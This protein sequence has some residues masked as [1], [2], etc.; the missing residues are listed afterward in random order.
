MIKKI[1]KSLVTMESICSLIAF[2]NLGSGAIKSLD[3]S[4][5]VRIVML[6]TG[7][8][9]IVYIYYSST[10]QDKVSTFITNNED[11]YKRQLKSS[12]IDIENK[13]EW[14]FYALAE[15]FP[16]LS[17]RKLKKLINKHYEFIGNKQ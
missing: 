14:M 3:M 10:Q 11:R 7:L 17:C 13:K 2:I 16:S 1:L 6:S 5:L 4:L 15:K 12:F 9:L 8:I